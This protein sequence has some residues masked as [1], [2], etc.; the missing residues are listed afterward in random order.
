MLFLAALWLFGKLFDVIHSHMTGQ[1][2]A[3]VL[4]MALGTELIRGREAMFL[5]GQL[6]LLLLVFEGGLNIDL[7]RFKRVAFRSTLIAF[8]GSGL[9][10]AFG[11]IYLHL[12]LQV[13]VLEA[14]SSGASL[15]STS[16]AIATV[17]MQKRFVD[18]VLTVFPFFSPELFET[19]TETDTRFYC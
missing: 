15:A 19:V 16:I 3:G 18:A 10:V 1:I 8:I 17:L 7:G 9:P 12:I 2:V 4:F 14:V 6:G 13:P 11:T 5:L